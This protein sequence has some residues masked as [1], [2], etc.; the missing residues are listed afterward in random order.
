M[1]QKGK[2]RVERFSLFFGVPREIST[3]VHKNLCRAGLFAVSPPKFFASGDAAA[4]PH[5]IR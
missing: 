3:R 1:N 2:E 5:A 4:T